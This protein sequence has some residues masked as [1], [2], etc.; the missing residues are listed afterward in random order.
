MYP[1]RFTQNFV[2]TILSSSVTFS[3]RS[4]VKGRRRTA[5]LFATK[6]NWNVNRV[7]VIVVFDGKINSQGEP[8]NTVHG[9][10][11][12]VILSVPTIRRK[13]NKNKYVYKSRPL[14]NILVLPGH[15]IEMTET[16][17]SI[18]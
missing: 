14:F 18:F 7:G 11:E 5:T 15:D 6:D 10:T 1:S 9:K 3:H 13:S 8:R 16:F 17:E 2:V 12:K 4:T